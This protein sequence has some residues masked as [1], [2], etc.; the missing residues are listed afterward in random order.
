[1]E[2]GNLTVVGGGEIVY[3]AMTSGSVLFITSGSL[4]T[5]DNAN[6][7]YD[8]SDGRLGLGTAPDPVAKLDITSTT[9]GFL[10]PRMDTSERDAISAVTGLMLYNTTTGQYEFFNGSIWVGMQGGA[11]S[12]SSYRQ[13]FDDTNLVSGILTA[14][15]SLGNQYN[16]VTVIDNNDQ[17]IV[18]DQITHTNTTSVD[19]D[20]T[21]FGSITGTWQLVVIG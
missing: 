5:Q 13:S 9:Q 14:T 6:F 3:S 1:M 17:T 18:P 19:I 8:S 7:F 20:L 11:G 15:H 2:T 21:S 12:V 4:I 16:S 10:A